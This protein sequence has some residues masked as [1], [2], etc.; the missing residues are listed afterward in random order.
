MIK[1]DTKSESERL[2][3]SLNLGIRHN[4]S[5]AVISIG[6][7]KEWGS[8]EQVIQKLDGF[9]SPQKNRFYCSKV[10]DHIL[11]NDTYNANPT[12]MMSAI[13][14]LN[15]NARYPDS[16][17]I[18]LGDMYELGQSS[19]LEHTIIL[20][21]LMTMDKLKL[22]ILVGDRFKISYQA[23]T[24]AKE[25]NF[26]YHLDRR[27]NPPREVL[28]NTLKNNSVILIKGSRGIKM[29]R[30]LEFLKEIII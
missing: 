22:L 17:I 16:Q 11:I 13:N 26:I 12:S 29:E 1:K 24:Q 14:E 21:E 15:T 5:N 8:S 18:F 2:N 3:Y 20:N 19:E 25:S 23:N 27:A 30:Y 4:C 9:V 6:L 10:G 7:L 28:E